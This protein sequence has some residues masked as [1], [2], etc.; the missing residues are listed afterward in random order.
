MK[1]LSPEEVGLWGTGKTIII[2]E[3]SDCRYDARINREA[4]SLAKIGFRI[5]VFMYNEGIKFHEK[6]QKGR[7]LYHQFPFP[8]RRK[9]KSFCQKI[10]RKLTMLRFLLWGNY[11][12]LTTKADIIHAHNLYFLFSSWLASELREIPLVYDAH[13]LHGEDLP[14]NNIKNRIRSFIVKKYER[15]F[16]R[17]ATAIFT[18]NEAIAEKIAV[19]LKT[20]KPFVLHNYTP[21]DPKVCDYSLQKE[22]GLAENIKIIYFSGGIYSAK[23]RRLDLI[24]N[25][26]PDLPANIHFIVI[27]MMNESIREELF[28]HARNL[29]V[30]N[31]FQILPSRPTYELIIAG[32]CADMGVIPFAGDIPNH[33]LS[34]PNKISEYL[35]AGL[36]V[37][38]TDYPIIKN[39]IESDPLGEAGKCFDINSAE[40]I[41]SAI[42][43]ILDNK[44][45][46]SVN[47]RKLA[48]VRYN[49]ETQEKILTD[50]YKN[51]I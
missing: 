38:A 37:I 51:L 46:L 11:K 22:A 15:F 40:S 7:I 29:K 44:E 39:Q 26:L 18:V 2:A 45:R 24:I 10:Q 13:E 33:T 9:N 17:K 6:M 50:A 35:M 25:V 32:A 20:D 42:L 5:E 27:G 12:V 41:K 49:W 1:K 34:S 47:A 48:K 4:D 8:G 36:P 16:S 23:S 28:L 3:F 31:R 21:Y 14:G 43:Y 19:K 30:E